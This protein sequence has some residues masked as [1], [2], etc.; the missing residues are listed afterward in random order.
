MKKLIALFA[1]FVLLLGLFAGCTKT[2]ADKPTEST[3]ETEAVTPP[4]KPVRPVSPIVG[5]WKYDIDMYAYLE[6]WRE[7]FQSLGSEEFIAFFDTYCLLYKD[8]TVL[9]IMELREDHTFVMR[10][11]KDSAE[12]AA[13]QMKVNLDQYFS[14]IIYGLTRM[15]AEELEAKL[16]EEGMT[17]DDAREELIAQF[18]IDAM[19]EEAG[20]TLSAQE[21]SYTYEDGKLTM[22]TPEIP[23]MQTIYYVELNGDELKIT[24][25]EGDG[26]DSFPDSILP[27]IFVR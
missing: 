26:V 3:T 27:M 2:P 12:A 20:A 13:A 16:A 5:T 24:G 23:G 11:D 8:T 6:A 7:Q 18:D 19:M 22:T 4:P 10:F 25:M 14:E 15:T 21:G 9:V 1:V 17:M